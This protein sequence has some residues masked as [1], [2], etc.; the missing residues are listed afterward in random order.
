MAFPTRTNTPKSSAHLVAAA[1]AARNLD[2]AARRDAFTWENLASR[3]NA[4]QLEILRGA[5]DV[6]IRIVRA[7]NQSGKSATCARDFS[8]IMN[9]EHP[10]LDVTA[11]WGGAPLLGIIAG[12]DRQQIEENLWARGV[13]PLLTDPTEW[14]EN[15]PSGSLV[16]AT[17]RRT[18]DTILF[19]SHNHASPDDIKHMQ[20]YSAH[21]VWCDEMPKSPAVI[22]ELTRRV[23]AKRGRLL[24]SFTQKVRN[25]AVRRAVDGL[26]PAISRLYRLS[27]LDNPI[28]A[29]RRQEE[30]DKISH[31]TPAQQ[32]AILEGD[33][34]EGSTR[35]YSI[36]RSRVVRTP[37]GYDP[38]WAHHHVVDPATESKLGYT[39]WANEPES[40]RWYCVRAGYI[41]GLYVPTLIVGAT[42]SV[43]RGL[44][45]IKRTYDTAAPWFA[46]QARAMGFVYTSVPEKSNAKTGWIAGC[47][48][49][50]GMQYFVAPWAELLLDE[51]ESMERSETNSDRIANPRKYHL[52]DCLHY[53]HATKPPITVPKKF[54][55][56]WDWLHTQ[57]NEAIESER[58][59]AARARHKTVAWSRS[60][61]KSWR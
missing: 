34:I 1:S 10:Y 21:V 55:S 49:R 44:N 61:Y 46:H 58:L 42:E 18:G 16:S 51:V 35:I 8:W 32:A 39:T 56:W 3:P 59:A 13:K 50:L 7:G 2:R 12:Q 41:E 5:V 40:D 14:K 57:R 54:E 27:K 43:V 48:E 47:Q 9:R 38:G 6:L 37:P 31:L 30:L 52:T 11:T 24:L 20:S 25:D 22:E 4:G 33:W 60:K 36:D 19:L 29:D 45:V 26:N 28:Y 53:F 23:D 15:R 17:N